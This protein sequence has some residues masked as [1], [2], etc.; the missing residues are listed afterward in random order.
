MIIPRLKLLNKENPERMNTESTKSS[1]SL[2]EAIKYV[3]SATLLISGVGIAIL[4]YVLRE[5]TPKIESDALIPLVE[6][7]VVEPYDGNLDF[8]VS[9]TVVPYREIRIAAEVGGRIAEKHCDCEA[10]NFITKDQE[11]LKI[12]SKDYELELKTIDS[13]ILREKKSLEETD[14]EITGAKTNLEIAESD[15]ELQ[16]SQYERAM[17]LK[18]SLSQSQ[19]DTAKRSLLSVESQ[20]V[21]RKNNYEMLLKKKERL[22]ASLQLINNR[23]EKAELNLKR[24]VVK[25]PV[26]GV[27]VRESVEQGDFVTAARELI[28]FEDTSQAEILINLTPGELQWLRK[29][30][31]N[32]ATSEPSRIDNRVYN[33]PKVNVQISDQADPDWA[34]SG[35]HWEGVL[36]RFDGIGRNETTKS[37]PCR[38]VIDKP[39]IDSPDSGRK[40]LVRGMFV[41]CR[42]VLPST[43]AANQLAAF[44]AVGLRPGDY[45]WA[46]RDEKLRRFDVNV[47]DRSL[48]R[49][50]LSEPKKV[51]VEIGS[52][53][54]SMEVGEQIVVSPLPQP[55]EGGRV[56]TSSDSAD[57]NNDVNLDSTAS[58]EGVPVNVPK[59]AA[60]SSHQDRS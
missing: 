59:Q 22:N 15:Y 8:E 24:T 9:G 54:S 28:V 49:P 14:Q 39:I 50:S 47:I 4:M 20:F 52:P 23:R 10:G 33:L 21:S 30:A 38:I 32:E 5:E 13:E 1:M 42:I 16:K 25:A 19:L 56:M 37:I 2:P 6:T 18:D 27:I 26:D 46:V 29:Y 44:P 3:I 60:T 57:A 17:R 34:A 53:L 51:V 48:Q 7:A 41:K 12:D 55:T 40:V 35:E 31:P 11:L 45:V 58:E 36:E 43:K